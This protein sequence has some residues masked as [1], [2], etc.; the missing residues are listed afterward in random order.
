VSASNKTEHSAPVSENV[1][2]TIFGIG[3][4]VDEDMGELTFIM[5]P[6]VLLPYSIADIPPI[7]TL[8]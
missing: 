4:L 3:G 2:D 6:I 1:A 7:S 8:I 5:P